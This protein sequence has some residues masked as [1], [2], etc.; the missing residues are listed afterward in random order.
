MLFIQPELGC[1]GNLVP[2]TTCGSRR[3]IAVP[4]AKCFK[5]SVPTA[6]SHHWAAGTN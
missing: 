5:S 2:R 1:K 6:F 3:D 4:D